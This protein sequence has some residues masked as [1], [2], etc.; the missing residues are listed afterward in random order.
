MLGLRNLG[1]ESA[2]ECPQID[3]SNSSR[4]LLDCEQSLF[5][6]IFSE[7]SAPA[8]ERQAA[9][10]RDARN[11]GP[12]PEKKKERLPAQLEQMKYALASQRKMRL[13]DA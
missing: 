8:R 2:Q 11:E 4:G 5:F 13:A 10:T 6:F 7:G 3:L 1:D 12:L 9:K